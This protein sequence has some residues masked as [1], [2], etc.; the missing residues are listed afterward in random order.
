MPGAAQ[1]QN[2]ATAPTHAGQHQGLL[3]SREA[4]IPAP[5]SEGQHLTAFYGYKTISNILDL[6]WHVFDTF[7]VYSTRDATIPFPHNSVSFGFKLR[8][9]CLDFAYEY[10]SLKLLFGLNGCC[11][12]QRPPL[13]LWPW[14]WRCLCVSSPPAFSPPPCWPPSAAGGPSCAPRRFTSNQVQTGTQRRLR[15]SCDPLWPPWFQPVLAADLIRQ[16]EE[17]SRVPEEVVTLQKDRLTPPRLLICYSSRDGPAHVKAV[18][19]F[20]AFVQKHMATQV[21]HCVCFIMA[22]DQHNKQKQHKKAGK[23]S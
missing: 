14:L 9:V 22:L 23:I 4:A 18:N 7:N 5:P 6:A 10:T 21:L 13:W 19:H 20:G 8:T 1:P 11:F 3:P 12:L 15:R 16:H 2:V 17:E